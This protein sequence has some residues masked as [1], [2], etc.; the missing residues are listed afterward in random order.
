MENL[1]LICK[2]DNE[3][4]D[5]ELDSLR[6]HSVELQIDN[7]SCPYQFKLRKNSSEPMHFIVRENSDILREL[8]VG[9]TFN[10]KYYSDDF[11]RTAKYMKTEIMTMVKRALKMM[12][13]SC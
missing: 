2:T 10:M 6:Y 11:F 7:L 5:P 9:K 13:E 8:Q 12:K 3:R 4:K 1:M